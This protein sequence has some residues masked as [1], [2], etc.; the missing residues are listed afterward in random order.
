MSAYSGTKKKKI[1]VHANFKPI[2]TIIRLNFSFY[3]L[4]YKKKNYNENKFYF[5]KK[6][7]INIYCISKLL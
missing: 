1:E 6:F 7:Y 5:K 2:C 4:N 3:I